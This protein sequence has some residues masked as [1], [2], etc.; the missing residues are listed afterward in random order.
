VDEPEAK[1]FG[2][3]PSAIGAIARLAYARG[4]AAGVDVDR[5][6]EKSELTFQQVD[7]LKVRLKV[8]DQIR[9][10]NFSAA[11]LDDDFLGFHLALSAELREI[12]LLYYVAASSVTLLEA[13]E[14]ACRYSSI[15]NEGVSIQ[16]SNDTQLSV[17]FKYVGVSRHLDRHQIE[18]FVTI[19]VRVCQQL[20]GQRVLPTRVRLFHRRD[21][22]NAEFLEFFGGNVEFG[23]AVDEVIFPAAARTLPVVSADPYLNKLLTTYCD[24]ALARRPEPVGSF[25]WAVEHV[26]AELLPHGR[27]RANEIARRLGVSPRTF[28]RRLSAEG[29]TY[30]QVLESFRSHLAE[31]YLAD[32]S[33]S[34]SQIAWLLG[35]Q[36]V[37]A[38]TH[39]YKRWTGKTPRE[40]RAS[41]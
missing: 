24:E 23:T 17:S 30:S 15:V 22:I 10:L 40:A 31:R 7:D 32:E 39:A 2:G 8:R 12:G 33:L 18:Y 6:L 21:G 36:E 29:V 14:R 11:E 20:T 38:F 1:R 41:S 26:I 35:Y 13:L 25:R 19:L 28:G 37:S 34:I 9:F 3:L 27:A 5:L 4:K 16:C